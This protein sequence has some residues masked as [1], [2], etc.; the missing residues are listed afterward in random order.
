MLQHGQLCD[1]PAIR[2]N[3]VAFQLHE[4]SHSHGWKAEWWLSG[5]EEWMVQRGRGAAALDEEKLHNTLSGLHAV[6]FLLKR[7]IKNIHS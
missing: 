3:I 2:D 4:S 5:L 6:R 7:C 1:T